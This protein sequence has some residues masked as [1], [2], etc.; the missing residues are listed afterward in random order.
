MQE[1][2][3]EQAD[4]SYEPGFQVIEIG[5]KTATFSSKGFGSGG[6]I[7]GIILSVEKTR[8]LWPFGTDD[9]EKELTDWTDKRPICVSRGDNAEQGL[10]ELV[11]VLDDDAPDVARSV[12]A[13]I[14][15]ANMICSKCQWAQFASLGK[16]QA[17][18]AGRRFLI[19]NVKAR[20]P[21][22]LAIT[23][24]SIKNWQQYRAGLEGGHFSRVVTR[25]SLNQMQRGKFKWS[26]V[27]FE[28]AGDVDGD[29]VAPLA[30]MVTYKGQ[31]MME[32]R[33]LIAEF[34][35]LELARDI[36]YPENGASVDKVEQGDDF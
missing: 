17:C 7:T 16:G 4:K 12:L 32:A 6:R 14:L 33:A 22:V 15:E 1:F 31:E 8:G 19:W 21:G 27:A 18:K 29:M 9:E 24:T 30:K 25:F 34:L 3:D 36:D 5:H 2:L 10:G 35:Q 26:T 23:P 11:K 13:P 28:S 20:I